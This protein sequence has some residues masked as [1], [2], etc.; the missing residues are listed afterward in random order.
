MF[1]FVFVFFFALVCSLSLSLFLSL[2]SRKKRKT[3]K[4]YLLRPHHLGVRVPP[5]LPAHQVEGERRQLLHADDRDVLNPPG[6]LPLRRELVVHLAAAQQQPLDLGLRR[7][8]RGPVG[9]A[10]VHDQALEAHA[11][12]V[13]VRGLVVELVEV[14]FRRR[15]P[16]QIFRAHH[17]ERLA[18]RA[19]ELAPQEVEVVGRRCDV[20]DLPVGALDLAAEVAADG[21]LGVVDVLKNN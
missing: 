6:P 4:P 5:H 3:K 21:P 1:F 19:V 14:G 12:D 9:G 11:L 18:E 16:Q 20:G 13:G 17:D 15:V 8:V 2:F 7:R 10:A